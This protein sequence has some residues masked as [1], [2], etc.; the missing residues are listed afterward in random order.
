MRHDADR[1]VAG[2]GD[3]S[4]SEQSEGR[5]AE[6]IRDATALIMEISESLDGVIEDTERLS[7]LIRSSSETLQASFHTLAEKLDSAAGMRRGVDSGGQAQLQ[8]C[9]DDAVRALQFE[10]ISLQLL[11][12]ISSRIEHLAT[13]AGAFDDMAEFATAM[14]SDQGLVSCLSA[15]LD[16]VNARMAQLRNTARDMHVG[17][18]ACKEGSIELF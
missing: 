12:Q 9:I 7:A 18:D 15:A 2:A 10:D 13:F 4:Q 5:G 1:P 17:R 6:I 11:R 8:A 3:A 16:R 14:R